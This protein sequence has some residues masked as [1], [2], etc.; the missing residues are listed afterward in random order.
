M[1]QLEMHMHTWIRHLGL[2]TALTATAL[3]AQAVTLDSAVQALGA[4]RLESLSL[5]GAGRWFQF[6]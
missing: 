3:A 2:A 6:G 4:D 1:K 5:E